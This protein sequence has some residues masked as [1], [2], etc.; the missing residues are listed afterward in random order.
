M[1]KHPGI[2]R[3]YSSGNPETDLPAWTETAARIHPERDLPACT[4]TVFRIHPETDLPAWTETV[5]RIHP[6]TDLL[7]GTNSGNK[8]KENEIL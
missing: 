2:L 1:R 4:E 7:T 3:L 5:F 8:E 6:E